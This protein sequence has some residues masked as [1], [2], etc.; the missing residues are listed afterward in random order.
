MAP[1]DARFGLRALA[2]YILVFQGALAV[3]KQRL[4]RS[5]QDIGVVS[6][7]LSEAAAVMMIAGLATAGALRLEPKIVEDR[8]ICRLNRSF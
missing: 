7:S 1:A 6:A 2:V 3:R 4:G 8:G 5:G